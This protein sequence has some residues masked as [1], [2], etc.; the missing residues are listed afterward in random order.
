MK[1]HIWGGISKRGATNIIMFTGIMNAECFRDIS[2]AGLLPFIWDTLPDG[3]RLQQNNDPKH[4]SNLT[5]N[6]FEEHAVNWWVTPPE[7]PDVNPIKNVWGS[8][9]Q[10]LRNF[11]KPQNLDQLK[12]GIQQFWEYR[13]TIR[14][15]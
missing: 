2:Q 14:L 12:D 3:H 10:Y 13:D 6:F 5:D 15:Y 11:Y 1:V 8:L 7:P 9:K 4:A